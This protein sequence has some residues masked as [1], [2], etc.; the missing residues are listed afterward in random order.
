[1]RYQL[2]SLLV[3]IIFLSGCQQNSSH[4]GTNS[5]RLGRTSP[6]SGT[7][8]VLAAGVGTYLSSYTESNI[9]INEVIHFRLSGSLLPD[10]KIGEVVS[11]D[12]FTISPKVKGKAYWSDPATI[13]FKSDKPLEYDA[14]YTISL[15]LAKLFSEIPDEFKEVKFDYH[16]KPLALSFKL[17]DIQYGSY[18]CLLYTSPSPRDATLSRMPSSA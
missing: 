12:I 10:N 2:I 13:S 1:M 5:S 15:Q 3:F 18:T 9:D 11:S 17:K 14:K 16:T 7:T 8:Q 4:T 6:H